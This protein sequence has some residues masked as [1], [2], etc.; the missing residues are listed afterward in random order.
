M[1]DIN[2]LVSKHYLNSDVLLEMI[3]K[4]LYSSQAR[5]L[6]ERASLDP[7][8]E[9]EAE[10]TRDIMLRLPIFRLSEKMWGKE[11]TE[12]RAIIENIMSKIIAKGNTLAEK[13]RILSNFIQ[14]PPQTN[15]ISEILSHIVFLDTLTNIMVHFNAS[16]AGFTFEGFLAAL[17]GG[18]QIPAGHAAGVQ[19]LINNDKMPISLKL[20]TGEGGEGKASV[21]GS[22]KD[23]CDHFID[24]GGL[25]QDPESGHYLGGTAGAEGHMTYVVALKSFRE[26]E[27]E[28]ALEGEQA[29]RFYQFDFNAYNFLDSMRSNPPN[30]KPLAGP[31]SYWK[32]VAEAL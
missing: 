5:R 16:A 21:E 7:E 31:P 26:K 30:V 22:F 11:G 19:D 14:S 4:E 13:I 27:A 8:S 29:I 28:E 6:I 20:L 1:V 23:L 18:I 2:K 32:V 12:D 17:L 3:Q 10:E 9:V 25:R 24:V 15:D